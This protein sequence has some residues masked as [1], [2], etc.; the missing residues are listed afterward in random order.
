MM[1]SRG[2]ALVVENNQ[3]PDFDDYSSTSL[4][5]LGNFRLNCLVQ[6]CHSVGSNGF[7]KRFGRNVGCVV[8]GKFCSPADRSKFRR[9][10]DFRLAAGQT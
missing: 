5:K 2:L 4:S 7:S 3:P 10:D 8:V 1:L 9:A 6:R